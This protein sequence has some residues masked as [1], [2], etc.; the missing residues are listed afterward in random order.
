M[1]KHSPRVVVSMLMWRMWNWGARWTFLFVLL[2][3]A[4]GSRITS[5]ALVSVIVSR[6]AE[7]KALP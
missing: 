7:C 5:G 1:M 2:R 3:Q 4:V 6:A